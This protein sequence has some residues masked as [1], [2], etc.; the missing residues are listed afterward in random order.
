MTETRLAQ[1]LRELIDS[2]GWKHVSEWIQQKT[3]YSR[4]SLDAER[5]T[6]LV[7]VREHQVRIAVYKELFAEIESRIK[8]EGGGASV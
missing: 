3:A 1:A 6:D 7:Q 5:F 2:E 8:R 4:I